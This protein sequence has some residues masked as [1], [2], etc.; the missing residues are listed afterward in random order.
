MRPPCGLEIDRRSGSLGLPVRRQDIEIPEPCHA[1]WDAMRP[2]DKGRFCFDCRK[3]VHDLSAMTKDEAKDFLRRSACN[4]ICV[5]YQHHE[6]GTLAFREPAPRP[7]TVVPVARLLRPRSVAA[8]VASAGMA[9]ALAA[10]APHGDAPAQRYAAEAPA[11]EAPGVV[12][13]IGVAEKPVVEDEPCDPEVTKVTE[14]VEPAVSG[15][16]RSSVR[17]RLQ[18]TAGKPV[19]MPR[20]KGDMAFVDPD[21]L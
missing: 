16:E 8:A 15:P 4:D 9:M 3:T 20:V 6:D 10:C 5:S 19:Q 14:P 18:R 11:F 21:A 2:E 1:D 7:S 13:P 17:G 12:I